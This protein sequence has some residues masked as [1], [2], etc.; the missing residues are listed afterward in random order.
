MRYFLLLIIF[1][2]V[3]ISTF[4]QP[5]VFDTTLVATIDGEPICA[6]EFN[7]ISRKYKSIVI[8]EFRNNY[9]LNYDN[10]FWENHAYGI[11]PAE[12]LH[13]KTLEAIVQ[14]KVQ[15]LLAKKLG[16]VQDISFDGF[17]RTYELEN[18]TRL[19]AKQ[20]NK[21]IFG[22]TQYTQEVYYDYVFSNLVVKI[23]NR[24]KNKDLKISE[25]TLKSI[26][27]R[28]KDSLYRM[29][30]YVR[31]QSVAIIKSFVSNSENLEMYNT[32]TSLKSDFSTDNYVVF[33]RKCLNNKWKITDEVLKFDPKINQPE[34]GKIHSEAFIQVQHILQGNVSEIFDS[35][36]EFSFFK[37]LERKPM[38]YRTFDSCKN[39]IYSVN[40]ELIYLNYLK[41][42]TNKAII[43]HY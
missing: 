29:N 9:N 26:Y 41:V 39:S 12:T 34:D 10:Q 27:E 4:S 2:L 31:I 13:K 32:L 24:L 25:S 23:K 8:Q 36:T 20:N 5:L 18:K 16:I 7:L 6:G 40:L 42:L 21:V 22:P 15:Q 38:G 14:L 33:K 1:F 28:D 43:V 30:D 37:V 17:I 3:T 11:S 35:P 19:E